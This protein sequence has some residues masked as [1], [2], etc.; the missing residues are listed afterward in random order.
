MGVYPQEAVI[1][2]LALLL[3]LPENLESAHFESIVYL[4]SFLRGSSMPSPKFK[5]VVK[6]LAKKID[7]EFKHLSFENQLETFRV[8]ASFSISVEDF[9]PFKLALENSVREISE[10]GFFKPKLL[11]KILQLDATLMRSAQNGIFQDFEVLHKVQ[12]FAK[13]SLKQAVSSPHLLSETNH[14]EMQHLIYTLAAWRSPAT[15]AE[16]SQAFTK[17]KNQ[18]TTLGDPL[19]DPF[20]SAL[21]RSP[22]LDS[23]EL[24]SWL[25]PAKGPTNKQ[26]KD[27]FLSFA[28]PL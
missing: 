5:D 25:Q 11:A 15:E 17:V 10:F 13:N 12:E 3:Q 7:P 16:A 8:L 26:L 6:I 2:N 20:V 14:G 23:P 19:N 28:N 22:Q 9:R 24:S 4:L 1:K 21:A 27:L 18:Y